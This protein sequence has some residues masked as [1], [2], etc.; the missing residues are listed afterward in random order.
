MRLP[1]IIVAAVLTACACHESSS[2]PVSSPAPTTTPDPGPAP[3][4]TTPPATDDG[5]AGGNSTPTPTA[6]ALSADAAAA[7]G[8]PC[9]DSACPEPLECVEYYGIAGPK[10]PKFT[11]CEVRCSDGATCPDGQACTTI[12]DGPGQVC[13]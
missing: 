8:K 6:N 4:P 7:Q 1:L 12:A 10:G 2:A 13:R 9:T 11:S 3:A 5:T